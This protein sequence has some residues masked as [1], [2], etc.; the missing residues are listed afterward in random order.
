MPC[1]FIPTKANLNPTKDEQNPIANRFQWLSALDKRT[2]IGSD[3]QSMRGT[4]ISETSDKDVVKYIMNLRSAAIAWSVPR[5]EEL[6]AD[7]LEKQYGEQV[8]LDG[9]NISN[10]SDLCEWIKRGQ[11]LSRNDISFPRECSHCNKKFV[12]KAQKDCIE[13]EYKVSSK[14]PVYMCANGMHSYHACV[15]CYCQTCKL[16]LDVPSPEKTTRT[17][18]RGRME[19]RMPSF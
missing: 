13:G 5:I 18:K 9:R 2:N 12:D 7:G 1:D 10:V 11:Y 15:F 17:S 3:G 4:F 16:E 8:R 19:R 6:L 14:T